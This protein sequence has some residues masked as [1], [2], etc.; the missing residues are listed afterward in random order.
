M[1]TF[2]GRIYPS[3]AVMPSEALL[4]QRVSVEAQQLAFAAAQPF[5]PHE[6]ITQRIQ[7]A[8]DNLTR[9]GVPAWRV[10]AAWKGKAHSWSAWALEQLRE[11]HGNWQSDTKRRADAQIELDQDRLRALHSRLSHESADIHPETIRAI[12]RVLSQRRS[13]RS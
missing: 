4:R 12:G 1:H 8:T 9:Y 3:E 13:G 2:S 6:N 10:E 11:A 5:G 7:R